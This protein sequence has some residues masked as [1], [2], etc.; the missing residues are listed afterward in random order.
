MH[1]RGTVPLGTAGSN[2]K[3]AKNPGVKAVNDSTLLKQHAQSLPPP[4]IG[5]NVAEKPLEMAS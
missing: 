2:V 3:C 1:V 4:T 5:K